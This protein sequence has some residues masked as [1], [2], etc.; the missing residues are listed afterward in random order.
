MLEL[1]LDDGLINYYNLFQFFDNFSV[2]ISRTYTLIKKAKPLEKKAPII[3]SLTKRKS[4]NTES[5]RSEIGPIN[6]V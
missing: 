6:Q 4:K 3:F 2:A 1:I 5:I